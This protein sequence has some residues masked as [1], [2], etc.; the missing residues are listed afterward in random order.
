M[1]RNDI[2]EDRFQIKGW[3]VLVLYECTCDDIDSII[4]T[5]KDINCPTIFIKEAL[6][7]LETCNL[8]TGLT[9]SNLTLKSSVIIINKT[10]SFEELINSIS[11]EYFH[12]ICHISKG[13]HIKNEEELATLNGNLNMRSY[14]I[15]EK[16][17][18]K[19]GSE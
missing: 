18:Q 7:N 9:Y 2:I 12:L 13:L 17:N 10:S 11:H 8:D 5:L 1:G 14:K 6:D 16:L 15:I 4:E 19:V 3:N